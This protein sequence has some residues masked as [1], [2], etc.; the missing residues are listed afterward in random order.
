[1]IPYLIFVML[2]VTFCRLKLHD[3]ALHGS[4]LWLWVAQFAGAIALYVGLRPVNSLVAEAAFICVFCPSATASPVVTGLL[5]G[6]VGRTAAYCLLSHATVA[7]TAP[8]LLAVI[9]GREDISFWE[10]AWLIG[11]NV[12][13]I[14]LGPLAVALLMRRFAPRA[15][16]ALEERQ[17]LSFYLWAFT[18]LIV[19]GTS[20]GKIIAEPRT[21]VPLMLLLA[22]IAAVACAVQ[23]WVGHMIGA[24]FQDPV[25]AAQSLGQKNTSLGIWLTLTYLNPIVSTSMVAYIAWHN[26]Y[27]SYQL[28]RGERR[29]RKRG[30]KD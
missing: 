2:L 3:L 5:G 16:K 1:M 23:F 8:L 29:A 28:Y 17:T 27:N 25:A 22:G 18:L 13:P 20:V 14:I 24:H 9:G 15:H 6:S 19:V 10:S 7:V 21:A 4:L 26:L 30:R 12:V 11:R